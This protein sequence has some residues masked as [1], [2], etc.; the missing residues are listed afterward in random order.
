MPS[1]KDVASSFRYGLSSEGLKNHTLLLL[2]II[3]DPTKATFPTNSFE[4]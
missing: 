3:Y 1:A 4:D 2:P